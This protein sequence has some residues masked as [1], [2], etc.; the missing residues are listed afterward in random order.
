M[1]LINVEKG[2][3]HAD[4]NNDVN[5]QELKQRQLHRQ[6][7]FQN[8]DN[9]HHSGA[10]NAEELNAVAVNEPLDGQLRQRKFQNGNAAE[11]GD[12][13]ARNN[14]YRLDYQ[15]AERGMKLKQRAEENGQRRNADQR[16]QAGAK[17]LPG[18]NAVGPD[19]FPSAR[20]RHENLQHQLQE[21]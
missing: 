20:G 1:A 5:R 10:V 18:A 12:D 19:V 7:V 13:I 11:V 4:N 3:A 2:A 17:Q 14:D 21:M 8:A 16:E 6:Q 9:H 15:G